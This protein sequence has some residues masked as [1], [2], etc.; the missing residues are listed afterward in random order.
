VP[1][2][3]ELPQTREYVQYYLDDV[4]TDGAEDPIDA[5]VC[6]SPSSLRRRRG[7]PCRPKVTAGPMNYVRRTCGRGRSR[8]TPPSSTAWVKLV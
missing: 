3:V 4:M 2:Y 1:S 7:R 6:R 8:L 5:I